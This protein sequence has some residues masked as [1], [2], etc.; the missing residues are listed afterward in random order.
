MAVYVDNF[1]A[2]YRGMIM[3]HMI[4]D[5]TEELLAI[6]D[7]IGVNRKWIQDAGNSFEHFDICLDKKQKAIALGAIEITPKELVKIK[8]HDDYINPSLT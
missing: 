6:V 1:N 4:A 8:K 5:T 2:K 7:A 3:C